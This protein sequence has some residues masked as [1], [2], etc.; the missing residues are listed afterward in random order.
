M[1][2]TIIVSSHI[3]PELADFCNKI[4][5]IEKGELLEAG[6]VNEIIRRVSGHHT[7]EIRVL[8][9][10]QGAASDLDLRDLA[11]AAPYEGGLSVK[12]G[13]AAEAA[14]ALLNAMDEITEV[15]VAGDGALQAHYVGDPRGEWRVLNRLVE[16][17]VRVLSFGTQATDLED[18]F[19]TVTKGIVS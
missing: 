4:G 2:K 9:D 10:E 3:L 14:I 6:D 19:L 12:T 7:L 16:G 13:R 18:I 1:G 5:I 11:A 8:E 17:G 15:K